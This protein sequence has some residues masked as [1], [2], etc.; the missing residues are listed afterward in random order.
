[1]PPA[2]N[3][4]IAQLNIPQWGN[5]VS[6]AQRAWGG[7]V[8][9]EG[10]PWNLLEWILGSSSASAML[11]LRQGFISLMPQFPTYETNRHV[12]SCP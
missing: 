4:S 8:W 11:K 3:F 7:A 9:V 12:V 10:E 2:F 1:M 5:D 6:L